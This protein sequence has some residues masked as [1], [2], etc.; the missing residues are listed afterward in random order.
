MPALC[1]PECFNDQGL[2]KDIIP[3]LSQTRGKCGYCS[4]EDVELVN[5]RDLAEVFEMLSGIYEADSNGKSLV[6][7]MKEDWQIFPQFAS[8]EI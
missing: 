1:C 5:P 6:E 7:W 4:A 3:S 8:L 2:R